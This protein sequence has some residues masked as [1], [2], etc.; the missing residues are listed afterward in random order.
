MQRAEERC[1]GC[2]VMLALRAAGPQDAALIHRFVVGLAEYEREREAVQVTVETLRQQ[3]ASSAPPF[4]CILAEFD[5][6]PAGFA[7]FFHTYSTWRGKR[8]VWLED[9]FVLSEYRR[10][11]IGEALF[12][13]VAAIARARD[14]PRLEW[15][16]LDWNQSARHFYERLG[17]APLREWIPYRISGDAL[18]RLAAE[19]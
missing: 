17:A 14:C 16:V 6:A 11:G 15:S 8:G 7:L 10:K 18:A 13:R 19:P 2:A 3:L 1:Y 12:G 9:L 4:E 5:E